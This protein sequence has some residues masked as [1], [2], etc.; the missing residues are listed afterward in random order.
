MTKKTRQEVQVILKEKM[1]NLGKAGTL[2]NVRSGY[3]RNYLIPQNLGELA[4]A[5]AI[6]A[7]EFNQQK[8]ELEEK[9]LI[10]TAFKT[11]KVLEE[12][13]EFYI[14]KR[15][16]ENNKIFG[17]ISGKQVLDLLE[18]QL[19]LNLKKVFVEIPEIKE[20]GRF[21]VTLR[22]HPSVKAK[23]VIEIQPK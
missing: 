17:S 4:T 10:E 9:K 15:I 22:L 5:K 7:M 12:I 20:V 6:K 13:N 8:L 1:P 21:P 18:S 3:A 19:Q 2:L 16:G 14:Q 23:I 11:K